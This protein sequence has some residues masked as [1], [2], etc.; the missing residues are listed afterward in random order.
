MG[1]R[2]PEK[3][4]SFQNDNIYTYIIKGEDPIQVFPFFVIRH[5]G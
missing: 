5:I 2:L 3:D 1:K 4:F